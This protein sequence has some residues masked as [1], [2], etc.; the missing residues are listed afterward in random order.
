MSLQDYYEDYWARDAPVPP[1]DPLSPTRVE[2]LRKELARASARRVLEVGCGAG[3]TVAALANHGFDAWGIDISPRAIEL[4]TRA[5]PDC[6]F[7]AH[8]V[9]DLPWPVSES[10]V[11]AVVA[12]E[13]IEHLIRPRRLLEGAHAVLSVGGHVAL[14]TPYHGLLK[15]LALAVLAFERHFDVEGDHI[16]FFTD[17]ELRRLLEET[18]FRVERVAHFGRLPPLWAGVFVWARKS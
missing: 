7:T 15:N 4:A 6:S 1:S 8:S 16:R 10:S 12:F 18:G 5:H 13:V 2:L 9:E 17:R 11:D 14:T 3:D